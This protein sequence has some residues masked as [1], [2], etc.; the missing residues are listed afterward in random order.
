MGN[1]F[2]GW[3]NR[4]DQ[5]TFPAFGSWALPLANL[6]SRKLTKVARS[7]DA[8]N[9]STKFRIDHGAPRAQRGFA[10]VNHNLSS[11]GRW[12][13]RIG[14]TP[15]GTDVYDGGWVN[16]W[17]MVLINEALR[18]GDPSWWAGTGGN[19]YLG[20]P[21]QAIQCLDTWY[22][23]RYTDIEIDDTANADGY[24]QIGRAFVGSGFMPLVNASYGLRDRIIDLSTK[25]RLESG[26]T[27]KRKRRRIRGVRLALEGLSQA[28]ADNLH[29]MQLQLGTV[30]EVLYVPD[31]EDAGHSQRYGY[32]GEMEEMG[33]LDYPF[34]RRRALPLSI[35]EIA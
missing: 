24:V 28:E 20:Y 17:Q 31:W 4:I 33:E 32:V 29:E 30:D 2:L 14:T 15:G 11:A 23:G 19:E 1:V 8:T 18:W 3:P 5:A 10:L 34:D 12:R 13:I 22:T 7:T 26:A 16:V 27:V 25:Q 21:Y 35:E 9:A 6:Q